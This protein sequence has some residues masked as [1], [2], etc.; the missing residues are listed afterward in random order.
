[1]DQPPI[2]ERSALE[3]DMKVLAEQIMA[4]RE[5]SETK[6][7]NDRQ[8]VKEAIRSF[9]SLERGSNQAQSA[10]PA[11][12][13]TDDRSPLPAYAQD[14]PAEVKLEIEYLIDLALKRGIGT[15]MSQA[16]KSSYFIQDAFHDALAGRL[17]PELK[18]QGIVS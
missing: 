10:S 11:G 12:Q 5:K 18:K 6:D 9:P 2:F 1:M 4:R 7:A 14:A 16:G 13:V 3:A 17:Y 15:A 8:I